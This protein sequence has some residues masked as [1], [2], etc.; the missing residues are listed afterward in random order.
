MKELET[1]TH[2]VESDVQTLENKVSGNAFSA[3]SFIAV[4]AAQAGSGSKGVSLESRT[5]AL[6]HAVSLARNRVTS[7]EQTVVG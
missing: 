7:L 1:N 5:A 3:P 2:M 4:A 6:E